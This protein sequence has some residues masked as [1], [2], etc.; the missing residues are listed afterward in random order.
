MNSKRNDVSDEE[1]LTAVVYF[2]SGIA[3]F[4]LFC[5]SS[6]QLNRNRYSEQSMQSEKDPVIR[7]QKELDRKKSD[8]LNLI[9]RLSMA[10]IDPPYLS[11]FQAEP[12]D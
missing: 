5:M 12:C 10:S 7:E 11:I 4:I 2:A 8:V 1:C 6:L 9:I 3:L